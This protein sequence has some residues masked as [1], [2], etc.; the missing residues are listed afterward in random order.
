MLDLA[1]SRCWASISARARLLRSDSEQG[2][3]VMIMSRAYEHQLPRKYRPIG[4]IIGYGPVLKITNFGEPAVSRTLSQAV[5]KREIAGPSDNQRFSPLDHNCC[6][7]ID[8]S[9][10]ALSFSAVLV[11]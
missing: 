9:I 6:R 11:M 1:S 2:Q 7:R 8:L 4:Q 3:P 10:L 5:Q